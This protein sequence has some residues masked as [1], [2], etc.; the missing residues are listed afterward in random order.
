MMQECFGFCK[1]DVKGFKGVSTWENHPGIHNVATGQ[2]LVLPWHFVYCFPPRQCIILIHYG[3]F[4]SHPYTLAD[5]YRDDLYTCTLTASVQW[6]EHGVVAIHQTGHSLQ[7]QGHTHAHSLGPVMWIRSGGYTPDRSLSPRSLSPRSRSYTCT[8]PRSSDVNTEWWLYAR[9][10]T[11]SKVKVV[12]CCPEKW[13]HTHTWPVTST[14]HRHAPIW[15]T[16]RHLGREKTNKQINK[17]YRHFLI[18]VTSQHLGKKTVHT[19]LYFLNYAF[20]LFLLFF[21]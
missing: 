21:R 5:R 18:W 15:V 4:H 8:Q 10:V 11:L 9:P 6:C 12:R 2:T 17:G 3:V 19:R 1:W 20:Y 7:G 14:A 16:S 13:S